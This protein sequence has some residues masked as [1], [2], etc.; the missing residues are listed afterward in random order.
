MYVFIYLISVYFRDL[1]RNLLSRLY[2]FL[3]HFS[4][5]FFLKF[6]LIKVL[7]VSALSANQKLMRTEGFY[8]L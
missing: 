7:I 5:I 8:L 3:I 2:F 1:Q 4:F 6:L